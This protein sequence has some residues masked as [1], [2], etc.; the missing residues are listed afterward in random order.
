MSIS[1]KSLSSK[2]KGQSLMET[3]VGLTILI[4]LGLFSFDLTYILIANQNNEKLADTA[5]RA[6]AN[7]A[8]NRSAL[9]AAE[10]VIEDFQTH[11]TYG[12]ITLTSFDFNTGGNGQVSLVTEIDLKLP[13][14]FGS[15]RS[16][17]INAKGLQP[18]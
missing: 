18:S 6:A 3:M 1:R 11:S 12:K 9:K 2:L 13:V 8:T 15:W 5:A 17:M 14:A 4:P 10:R 16:M 7:Y